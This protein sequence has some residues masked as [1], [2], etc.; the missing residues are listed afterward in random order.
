MLFA[1]IAL[2]ASVASGAH[3]AT[4]GS[5]AGPHAGGDWR[6]YGHDLSNTRT[7]P[8][9]TID[10]TKAGSLAP[11]EV[12][13]TANQQGSGNINSTP[14][15]ADGC[16]FFATDAGD[17]YALNAD[18]LGIVW[19]DH[20]AV[21]Q[22]RLGG[23]ITGAI[24]IDQNMALVAVSDAGH[25]FVAALD[26]MTGTEKWR[27]VIDDRAGS[28]VNASPTPFNGMI[29]EGFAGD[30]YGPA[31]RGGFAI[32][33][34]STGAVLAKHYTI[35]DTDFDKGYYGGS[36]WSTP[37]VDT[38]SGYLY[39][40]AGNPAS[41]NKEHQYTDALLKIDVDPARTATFGTIVDAYKGNVDQY[42][43]GLDRQPV[44][45]ANPD[46]TYAD[47]WSATCVQFD[48]DFG[49]SP[50]LF[51]DPRGNVIVGDLQKSGVYHA[52]YTKGMEQAW[53]ALVGT[54]CFICNASSPAMDGGAVFAA[55]SGSGQLAAMDRN[56]GGYRWLA[57]LMD[58][59]HYEG[60]SVANGVVYV[61]D[62]YGNL[63]AFDESSGLPLLKRNMGQ[64]AGTFVGGTTSA[65]AAIARDT[66]YVPAAG[67]LI[68]YR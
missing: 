26:E 7:Q 16:V 55:G 35:P 53:T 13:N 57:P 25:P 37:V 20:Y 45:R 1:G 64:D 9:S 34:E 56:T 49:A 68:A 67:Y 22:T 48:L 51:T 52:V 17:V 42:Y 62:F 23:T 61:P 32:L 21:G 24:S 47:A 14:T 41:H 6:L 15:V 5:C 58:L 59:V 2:I 10:T 66:V 27:S 28:F 60:V 38:A 4:G 44:C 30:E 8:Q 39:V 65:G 54:P 36:V 18:N 40:G 31:A 12:F 11:A 3:G 50:N 46:V 29:F 33:D 43:P 19:H 63:N